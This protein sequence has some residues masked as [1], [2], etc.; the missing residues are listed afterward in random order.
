MGSEK[1]SKVLVI[2]NG[3]SRIGQDLNQAKDRYVLVGC[4]AIHRHVRVDHIICCDRRMGD[5]VLANPLANETMLYVRESW[6]HYFRKINK[7]KNTQVVPDLP[8]RGEGKQ[9]QPEHWGSGG[10][11]VLVAASLGYK[12]ITLIG[13]DLYGTNDR[14]NN[15]YKGTNN[16]NSADSKP[17]DYSYWIY[18]IGKVFQYYPDATFTVINH[19]DWKMPEVWK[20]SNVKFKTFLDL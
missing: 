14:V 19:A 2:G 3:E 20:K 18:Q 5:E 11:A 17:V 8:Y 15:V 7:R 1:S 9:D 4:N 6:Y 16:Y 13:F 10:Y 12:N